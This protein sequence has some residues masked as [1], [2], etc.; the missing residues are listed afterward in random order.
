MGGAA[1]GARNA[2]AGPAP[3]DAGLPGSPFA[4][5]QQGLRKAVDLAVAF[6]TLADAEPSESPRAPVDQADHPHRTPLRPKLRSRRPGEAVRR[7]EVCTAPV[8]RVPAEAPRK[9]ARL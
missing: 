1:R 8:N 2:A 7:P 9:R 4:R 3:V 5:W 6:A